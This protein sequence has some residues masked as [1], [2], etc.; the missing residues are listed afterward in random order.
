MD[1]FS[2]GRLSSHSSSDRRK[3]YLKVALNKTQ[4]KCFEE[5]SPSDIVSCSSQIKKPCY[6]VWVLKKVNK[7]A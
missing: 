7:K 4:L 5:D 3:I 1:R 2:H 6:S